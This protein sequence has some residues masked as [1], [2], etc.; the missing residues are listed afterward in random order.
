M[1]K[2]VRHNASTG[3]QIPLHSSCRDSCNAYRAYIRRGLE[4]RISAAVQRTRFHRTTKQALNLVKIRGSLQ[5][6][7]L[8]F[9]LLS[10]PTT[11]EA[12]VGDKVLEAE[13]RHVNSPSKK[14]FETL[15]SVDKVMC[16]V[17]WHRKRVILLDFFEPGQTNSEPLHRDAKRKTRISRVRPEKKT[18]LLKHDNARPHTSLKTVAHTVNLGW[19]VVPHPP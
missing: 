3:S 16:T 14:K 4:S 2:G 7:C 11:S 17:F 15:P 19:T 8:L 13:W 18:F 6:Q 9:Y 10:W 12:D 5:N 1:Q